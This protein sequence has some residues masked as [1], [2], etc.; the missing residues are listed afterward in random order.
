MWDFW[1]SPIS[2]MPYGKGVGEGD[3]LTQQMGHLNYNLIYGRLIKFNQG[4][5]C[6]TDDQRWPSHRVLSQFKIKRDSWED[7]ETRTMTT[8]LI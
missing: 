7:G 1:I 5:P 6:G 4:S 3:V 2:I 8:G